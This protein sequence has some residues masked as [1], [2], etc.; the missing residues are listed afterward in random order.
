MLR[1]PRVLEFVLIYAL[2]QMSVYGAIF[3]LPAEVS[4]LMR[5]AG[6]A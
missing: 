6:G 5:Q 4:A 3:Y 2:I 1:D